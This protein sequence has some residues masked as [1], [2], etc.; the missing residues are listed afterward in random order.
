MIPT[1][2]ILAASCVAALLCLGCNSQRPTKESSAPAPASV[3]IVKPERKSL[4]R[5][6][7]QPGTIQP[8]EQT[9]LVAKLPGFVA[10]LHADIGKQVRGPKLDS[11]GN[12]I[13][14]G[15]LLAELAIP[16]LEE[17]FNQKMAK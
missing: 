1:E 5:I 12:E 14:P 17:E 4:N 7:E 10:K 16:E 3:D 15:E 11:K 8:D 2:R 6:V 13:E 9:E